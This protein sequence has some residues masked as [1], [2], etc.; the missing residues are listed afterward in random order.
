[1]IRYERKRKGEREESPAHFIHLISILLVAR[2]CILALPGEVGRELDE[3]RAA[4][5][6]VEE[7]VAASQMETS[8]AKCY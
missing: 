2:S 8:M 1:M 3:D 7:V 4:G 5:V 6:G